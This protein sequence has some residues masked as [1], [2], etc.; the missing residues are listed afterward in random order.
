MQEDRW[1][2]DKD[3]ED[4]MGPHRLCG[5]GT[6]HLSPSSILTE[7]RGSVVGFALP[8]GLQMGNSESFPGLRRSP[9][10]LLPKLLAADPCALPALGSV[11]AAR[12]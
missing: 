7:A 3:G 11:V 8:E 5:P 2:T 9:A 4:D 6:D 12:L 1:D 10:C